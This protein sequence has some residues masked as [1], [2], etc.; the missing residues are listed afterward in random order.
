MEARKTEIQGW[1]LVGDQ[2]GIYKTLTQN[3][4]K[5]KPEIYL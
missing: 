3:R 4:K 1:L 2:P 5:N